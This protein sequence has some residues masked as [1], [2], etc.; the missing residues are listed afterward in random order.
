MGT[1]IF[2][3]VYEDGKPCSPEGFKW[4]K[5]SNG[6]GQYK[7]ET[8]EQALNYAKS[9]LGEWANFPETWDGKLYKYCGESTI[10]IRKI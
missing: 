3:A 6:W 10:E 5:A 8:F 7:F 2:F 1:K 9:W 4:A